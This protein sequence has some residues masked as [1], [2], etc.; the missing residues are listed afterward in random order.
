[1]GCTGEKHVM[2]IVVLSV[3]FP[4]PDCIHVME[5]FFSWL[6]LLPILLVVAPALVG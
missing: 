2:L 6:I 4:V 5:C 1:M 3:W